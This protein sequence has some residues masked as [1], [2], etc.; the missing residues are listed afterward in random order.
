MHFKIKNLNCIEILLNNHANLNSYNKNGITP[1]MLG[2]NI[3]STNVK[4][5]IT[6][7]NF[8]NRDIYEINENQKI[9]EEIKVD[10]CKIINKFFNES[11]KNKPINKLNIIQV[12]IK[13]LFDM[14]NLIILLKKL[15]Q[16][17]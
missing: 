11:K 8:L 2:L 6:A 10:I 1:I 16:T 5:Y 14:M 12:I 7:T 3:N 13:N 9:N 17:N 15:Y 4:K